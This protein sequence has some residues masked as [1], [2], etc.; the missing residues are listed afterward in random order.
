M[1][2][3]TTSLVEF[4]NKGGP[5]MWPLLVALIVGVAVIIER[6]WTLSRASIDPK[7]FLARVKATLREDGLEAAI[8]LC[9]QTR[10]PIA[11]IFRAG[12]LRAER[13]IEH[14]EKAI[15]DAGTVE[16]AFL[17][18]GMI[19][20]ATVGNIAPLLGFLGTVSGMIKAFDAIA[21]AGDIEPSLVA[22]GISEALITTATGLAIAIPIQF[23]HN[24]FVSRI[25]KLV[26]EMEESSTELVDT[27]IE[28]QAG[29]PVLKVGEDPEER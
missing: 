17:E 2:S 27:L 29:R 7:Q 18:R 12:L 9:A 10:G 19:W 16:T 6:I 26:I 13:G 3:E 1:A 15:E 20:L 23:A 28:V 8:E 14:V 4:F 5:F 22:G 21:R 25:D 11:S 24:F